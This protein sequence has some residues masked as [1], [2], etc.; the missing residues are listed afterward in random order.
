MTNKYKIKLSVHACIP[1]F[2]IFTLLGAFW[3]GTVLFAESMAS[4]V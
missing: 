3:V 1:L 2:G 4:H